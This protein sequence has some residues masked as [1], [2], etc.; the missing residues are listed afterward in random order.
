MDFNYKLKWEEASFDD[1]WAVYQAS[2]L[3]ENDGT[4]KPT[5]VE[6]NIGWMGANFWTI[7]YTF[8]PEGYWDNH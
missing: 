3:M 8:C 5:W 4:E 2:L 7:K 6:V 1:R